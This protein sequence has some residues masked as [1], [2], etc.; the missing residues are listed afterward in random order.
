MTKIIIRPKQGWANTHEVFADGKRVG[1]FRFIRDRVIT[2][3]YGN[4]G[5]RR[6][7]DIAT[8]GQ[9]TDLTSSTVHD[10]GCFSWFADVKHYVTAHFDG[11]SRLPVLAQGTPA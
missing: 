6:V 2:T 5:S 3:P 10:L 7:C 9:L 11:T 1:E 8:A 4:G